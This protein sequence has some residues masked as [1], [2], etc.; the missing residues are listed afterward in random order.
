MHS[1]EFRLSARIQNG[2]SAASGLGTVHAIGNKVLVLGE[3][4]NK[5]LEISREV[6]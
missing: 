1:I 3:F 2:M 5:D 4:A 6:P